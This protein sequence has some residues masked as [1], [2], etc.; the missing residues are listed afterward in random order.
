M[1]SRLLPSR[2]SA[3]RWVFRHLA[4]QPPQNRFVPSRRLRDGRRYSVFLGHSRISP[5]SYRAFVL[6]AGSGGK[7][8]NIFCTLFSSFLMLRSDLEETVSLADPR[9]TS[10]LALVS[11]TSITSVPTVYVSSVVVA[12]PNPPP[13]RQ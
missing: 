7:C 8:S 11:N 4:I 13:H 2:A 1:I 3:L 12:V 9:Q 5:I 6:L 10:I